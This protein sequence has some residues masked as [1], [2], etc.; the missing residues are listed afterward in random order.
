[1]SNHGQIVIL[2]ILN[3]VQNGV[4]V[5]L[6]DGEYVIG[7]GADD[8]L[9]IT[10]VALKPAH[11][12]L[13]IAG[14]T[15][16][17][18]AAA[19]AVTTSTGLAIDAGS[20]T[21]HDIDQL[22]V[23]TV[24]TTR[25]AVAKASANWNQ[26]LSSA[27]VDK[28]AA[29]APRT[30]GKAE[31]GAI[32]YGVPVAVLVLLLV[33]GAVALSGGGSTLSGLVS[34]SGPPDV[35]VVRAAVDR[36]PFAADVVVE[37]EVDGTI[38]AR[39]YVDTLVER[40]AISEAVRETDVPVRLRLWARDVLENELS[41]LV[42]ARGLPLTVAI[43]RDGTVILKGTVLEKEKVDEVSTLIAEQVVGVSAVR[44]EVRTAETFLEETLAL[45][46]RSK[47]LDGV[48]FRLTSAPG[49]GQLIEATGAVRN[50]QVDAWL[51]FLKSYA[52]GIAR[53]MALRSYVG[54]EGR[55]VVIDGSA[56]QEQAAAGPADRTPIIL[57]SD[58]LAAGTPGRSIPLDLL[59]SNQTSYE[60]LVDAVAP[61]ARAEPET[62]DA[63]QATTP[64]GEAAAQ[65]P[66][67]GTAGEQDA[68]AAGAPPTTPDASAAA[69]AA[70]GP[71]DGARPSPG[72]EVGAADDRPAADTLSLDVALR[73]A[74]DLRQVASAAPSV[75]ILPAPEPVVRVPDVLVDGADA[76]APA[77]SA[78]DATPRD[79]APVTT[80]FDQGE[81]QQAFRELNEATGAMLEMK[82]EDRLKEALGDERGA[83][84]EQAFRRINIRVSE[85]AAAPL[86]AERSIELGDK[87]CWPGS[88]LSIEM[89]PTLVFWLD[90]LSVS[91]QI[92]M[93]DLVD[94]KRGL[95]LE[96]GLSPTRVR[97]CLMRTGSP[98][99]MALAEDSIYLNEARRNPKFIQFLLREDE[100]YDLAIVG[101]KTSGER[102]LQVEGGE[103]LEE[104]ASP[105][106]ESRISSIGE[107]GVLVRV[108][109][110]YMARVYPDGM[111]WHLK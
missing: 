86:P 76:D 107:L 77:V 2:K 60:T 31:K 38:N 27:S 70:A 79:D 19:G 66:P 57:A 93:K 111:P 59:L 21:W 1:M 32:R 72:G 12:R 106:I 83:D 50:D 18:A 90:L 3:G 87:A 98:A 82:D 63:G 91:N 42:A 97:D 67:G 40:R 41:A 74:G 17:I 45:A 23:V 14:G 52:A 69:D 54:I 110:G 89:L 78:A 37:E 22:E 43:E 68:S 4:E 99:M 44:S 65:D 62:A 71:D 104:G 81:T 25:F 16:S 11:A 101:A 105:S 20:A 15:I 5:A 33:F 39:G 75:S 64:G 73:R 94:A 13:R 6:E 29:A 7:S 84:L 8:D 9:Q 58:E 36:F 103:T 47:I 109:K 35:E 53:S 30:P 26:L 96:A 55:T 28:P 88:R 34:K 80:H 92:A 61:G 100:S 102:Y 48:L 56:P 49:G 10:D 108:P 85:A 24:A 51:G 46:A 95:V